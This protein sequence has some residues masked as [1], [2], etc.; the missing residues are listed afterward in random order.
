MGS[1]EE[2]EEDEE[3]EVESDLTVQA[4]R[5]IGTSLWIEKRGGVGV[6]GGVGR[7]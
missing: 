1:E 6:G 4:S 2:E 7:K 5:G 3:E